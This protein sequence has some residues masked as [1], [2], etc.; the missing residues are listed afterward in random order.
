MGNLAEF[1]APLTP[2]EVLTKKR[3]D[4]LSLHRGRSEAPVRELFSKSRL[5]DLACAIT[6]PEELQ[7]TSN[8]NTIPF[9]FLTDNGRVDRTRLERLTAR[10]ASLIVHNAHRFD[11]ALGSIVRAYMDVSGKK[12]WLGAIGS[13]GSMGALAR[14]SDPYD[15]FMVQVE[16]SKHWRIY[17]SEDAE[18]Q[19][20]AEF[21]LVAG[22]YL[23]VPAHHLHEC[24]TI[25]GHSLHLGLGFAGPSYDVWG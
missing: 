5:I 18:A 20:V 21:T 16:G 23:F 25:G 2:A 9:T 13:S 11:D 6:D 24:D 3:R 4:A 17:E 14:H 10:G 19:P 22:D 12:A 15:I 8:H 7:V 1:L